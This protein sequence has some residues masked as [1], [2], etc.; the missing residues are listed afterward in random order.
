M[1]AVVLVL[2]AILLAACGPR[3]KP[4]SLHDQSVP[5]DSRRYVADTQDAV[6][7][8]RAARDEALRELD[9][10]REW[11][12]DV[13][14]GVDWPAK[15]EAAIAKLEILADE[16]MKLAE[17][18]VQQ[19]DL[20]LALAQ[21]KY[22]LVTAETAVRH[23]IASYDLDLFR[24]R[25]EEAREKKKTLTDQILTQRDKI[26]E[27]TSQWWT[28]YA[29]WARSGDT[30][31]YYVPF[32]DVEASKAPPK[33]KKKKVAEKKPEEEAEKKEKATDPE[34]KEEADELRIW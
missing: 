6:S 24:A 33:K 10:V 17:L 18:E 14:R 28:A 27:L 8:A 11:R 12:R 7:I 5:A 31:L 29:S 3:V 19:A 26:D 25:T 1:T 16:R 20:A 13:V 21:A 22:E 15:A 9:A 32:I 30:R 4:I 23:D 2:A 34:Q